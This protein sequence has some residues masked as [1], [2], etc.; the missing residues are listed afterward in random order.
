MYRF[1]WGFFVRVPDWNVNLYVY[2]ASNKQTLL[3]ISIYKKNCPCF[4]TRVFKILMFMMS[5]VK[6]VVGLRCCKMCDVRFCLQ[7]SCSILKIY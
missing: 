4:K 1:F 5:M 7:L 2:F 3:N 6:L